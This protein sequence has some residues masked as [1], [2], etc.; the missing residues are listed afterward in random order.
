VRAA[1]WRRSSG[2]TGTA[3]VGLDIDS[4][5]H[6]GH[7]EKKE[8]TAPN[9]KGGVGFHPIYCFA[10]ATGET[11]GVLLRPGNAGANTI[12]DHVT[13]LDRAIAPLPADVA[14]GPRDRGEPRPLR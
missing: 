7:S 2:T 14:V 4:S 1:V 10:D 8:Q 3:T 9:Y 5:L 11:L 13:V 12:G 6:Q